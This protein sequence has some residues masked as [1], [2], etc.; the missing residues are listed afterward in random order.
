[1]HVALVDSTTREVLRQQSLGVSASYIPTLRTV[2][3]A[4]YVVPEGQRLQLQLQVAES[5]ESYVAFRLAAQREGI[6]NL[7]VNGVADFALGPLAYAHLQ[8]GSG[9]RAA[10]SG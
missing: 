3:F 5:E 2:T 8:T 10:I 6:A 7:A 9:L 1:M 4:S